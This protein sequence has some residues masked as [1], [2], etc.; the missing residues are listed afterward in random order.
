MASAVMTPRTVVTGTVMSEICTVSQKAD[1]KAGREIAVR[2]GS[3]PPSK[4]R[5]KTMPTGSTSRKRR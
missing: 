3:M 4:A 5:R 1:W 2:K